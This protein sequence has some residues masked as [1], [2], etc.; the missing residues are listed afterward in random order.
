[1]G[2]FGNAEWLAS[3]FPDASVKAAPTSG[4]FPSDSHLDATWPEFIAGV[5]HPVPVDTSSADSPFTMW[6][7][8]SPPSCIAALGGSDPTGQCR[9]SLVVLQY[10]P[11]DFYVLE[12][13]FDNNAIGRQSFPFHEENTV[14]G[15]EYLDK[16]GTLNRDFHQDIPNIFS[17]SCYD[18]VYG[19]NLINDPSTH[20]VV[21]GVTPFE[22]V[23]DWFWETDVLTSKYHLIEPRSADGKPENPSC[24]TSLPRDVP[25]CIAPCVQA[26]EANG[27]SCTCLHNCDVGGC[28]VGIQARIEDFLELNCP[29][30]PLSTIQSLHLRPHR[31]NRLRQK[32]TKQHKG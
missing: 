22:L 25:D 3:A 26:C 21:E 4:L 11:V 10:T 5:T 7:A 27:M 17:A 1:M 31:L 14:E 9:L 15:I 29:L 12:S 8:H 6:N 19:M 32:W 24:K 2:V 28:S 30:G 13:Q 23:S 18:H 16:F 20:T